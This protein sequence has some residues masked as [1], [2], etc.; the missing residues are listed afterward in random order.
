MAVLGVLVVLALFLYLRFFVFLLYVVLAA[1]ANLPEHWAEGLGLSRE[2]LLATLVVMVA[3]SLLN[4]GA[5]L[6]PSGLEAKKREPN[7]EATRVLV[8]AI[9]RGNLS[10]VKTLL[11]MDFDLD[12]MDDQ[13]M[14][15]LM[16][17][18]QRGDLKMI[19]MMLKKGASSLLIGPSGKASDVALAHNFPAINEFL[20]RIGE[21]EAAEAARK[22]PVQARTDSEPAV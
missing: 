6:L 2:M 21:A 7:P 11:T 14:S 15:P 17:A 4:Y 19:Q 12:T 5:K 10:Y 20:Q 18:A 9:E 16:R 13:G 22:A 1:G 3:M 8:H